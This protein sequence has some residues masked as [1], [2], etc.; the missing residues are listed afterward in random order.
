[1]FLYFSSLLSVYLSLF[2]WLPLDRTFV[3][4]VISSLG[5]GSDRT[6]PALTDSWAP[7]LNSKSGPPAPVSL[8]FYCGRWDVCIV[9]APISHNESAP[10]EFW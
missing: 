1:L 7:V 3:G 9:P 5:T 2:P 10:T 6:W 4:F 8:Y